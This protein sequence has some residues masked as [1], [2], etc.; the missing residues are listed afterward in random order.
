MALTF[1]KI[2]DLIGVNGTIGVDLLG[3]ARVRD[4]LFVSGYLTVGGKKFNG[5]NINGVKAID[6]DAKWKGTN[7][8]VSKG[9][10]GA[11]T[12]DDWK[13]T[14]ITTNSDGTLNYDG[15]TATAPSLIS[16]AGTLTP[17]KGGTGQDLSTSTGAIS[18]SGGTVSAGTLGVAD[19]GTGDTVDT[20][21]KNSLITTN[22]NGTLNY[23][24]TGATAPNLVNIAGTLTIAKGGTGETNSNTWL[25]S[26][27][28]INTD[29]TLNYAAGGSGTPTLTTLGGT[30]TAAKGGTGQDL[31]TSTGAISILGGTVSAGTLGVAD[32]GTGETA[33][34][35]W[36]NS[37]IT[38]KADGTLNY[39]GTEAVTPDI[40]SIDGTLTVAKG[41]TGETASDIWLNSRITTNNDGTLNY[42]ATGATAPNIANIAGTL[43]VGKGG[44][45]ETNSN[46]WLNSRVQINTDGTLNYAAGGSGTPT[47]TTLGGT[48]TTAKGGTGQDLSGSTGLIKVAAGSVSAATLVNDDIDAGAAIVTSKL[49]GA[50]TDIA[51]HGL[52]TSATTD[53]TDASNI[54]SGTLAD[55]RHSTIVTNNLDANGMKTGRSLGDGVESVV[56][57]GDSFRAGTGTTDKATSQIWVVTGAATSSN[58]PK[59]IFNYLHD[60]EMNTIRFAAN[61]RSETSMTGTTTTATLEIYAMNSGGTAAAASTGSVLATGN[62]TTANQTFTTVVAS[63]IDVSGLSD[64]TV[65]RGEISLAN[66]GALNSYMTGA[67]VTSIG[68]VA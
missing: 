49:T 10:T 6:K 33:S 34:D 13:N 5:L 46:T 35:I 66:S 65:Y 11:S 21:W 53:T 26:R 9:G 29:G 18:I 61:I 59:I 32:G 8:E 64:A 27:V 44:T 31:S 22:N 3:S 20:T 56:I 55:A 12:D 54:S 67:M 28:Q 58:N 41:G 57:F 52:A 51:S 38:T 4:D 39:D 47:L 68:S 15:T 50:A 30:L 36:L 17:K 1:D 23:D 2:K 14:K 43:T 19:G 42:D 16:I 48:L 63:K 24:G 60:S 7:I 37:R 25:N 40:A 45:G 62:I